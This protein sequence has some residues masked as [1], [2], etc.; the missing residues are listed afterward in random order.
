MIMRTDVFVEVIM[1]YVANKLKNV[2]WL[3]HDTCLFLPH[4]KCTMGMAHE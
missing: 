2:Q 3:K 1:E 4:M